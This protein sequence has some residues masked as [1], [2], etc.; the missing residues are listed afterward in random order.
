VAGPATILAL[1]MR[2]LVTGGAGFIGANLVRVLVVDRVDV[3][4]LDDL[5]VGRHPYLDGLDVRLITGSVQDPRT[6][7]R[8]IRGCDAVVHLAARSGVTPSVRH[9]DRDF[10]TNVEGTF[11]VL[12]A[13]RRAGVERV[14]F[15][16]SGAV[17][18][19]AKPPLSESQLPSPLAPYGASKLYGE[20][21][22]QAFQ[23]SYGIS[24]VALRFSNV[25]GPY[26]SHKA[27]VVAAFA[28]N[29]VR[30][31]PLVI[32]GS[33][34]QTRDFLHVSDVTRAV[35]SALHSRATGVLQLGTGVETS[36]N[37]LAALVSEAAGRRLRIEHRP[38]RAVE[39][40]RN[41][42]DVS[43]ARRLLRFGPRVDLRSGLADTLAW[44]AEQEGKGP[45]GRSRSR[46]SA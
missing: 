44:V 9:P 11:N 12:D 25:Y 43:R 26:C 7:R 27:S 1:P 8:A 39:A 33:G 41:V 42:S 45:S 2:V 24:S 6:V 4:V 35:R 40:A 19:G 13:A 5:S 18:A 29:A 15:A 36:I 38:S 31:R 37:R 23:S 30:D 14:V 10:R 22:L 20:A 17:L 16:S 3:V 34:R 21:A 32:Y 46:S 28:R